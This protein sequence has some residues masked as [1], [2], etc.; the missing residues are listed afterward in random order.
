MGTAGKQAAPLVQT[1][2]S[3]IYLVPR[4]RSEPVL[5]MQ[6]IV[7]HHVHVSGNSSIG[8]KDVWPTQGIHTYIC[9]RSLHDKKRDHSAVMSCYGWKDL[10]D[11]HSICKLLGYATTTARHCKIGA[12]RVYYWIIQGLLR[13]IYS[14]TV[15][16]CTFHTPIESILVVVTRNI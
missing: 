5:K 11:L 8:H 15:F 13:Y 10:D 3:C 4:I 16:T 1:T 12:W 9:T 2:V 6:K 7:V 14:L